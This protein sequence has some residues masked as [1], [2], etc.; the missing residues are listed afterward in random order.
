MLAGKNKKGVGRGKGGGVRRPTVRAK[1]G[2]TRVRWPD[3]SSA[4]LTRRLGSGCWRLI[5]T[6]RWL[7]DPRLNAL[8]ITAVI[9][10]K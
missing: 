4:F 2:L 10:R 5:R 1:L 3:G 6:V 8:Q 9:K 7:N